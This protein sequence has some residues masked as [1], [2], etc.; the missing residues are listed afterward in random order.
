MA[1]S[2][3]TAPTYEKMVEHHGLSSHQLQEPCPDDVLHTLAKKM[4]RW[5]N[6]AVDL[7]LDKIV[8]DAIEI[9]QQID[10]EGK[11]RN[12]LERWKEKFGHAATYERLTRCLVKSERADLA[13]LV[14]EECKKLVPRPGKSSC[15]YTVV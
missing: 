14:C 8:V 13:D 6:V 11:R 10:E 9:K 1:M 12:L 3:T 4:N 7:E 15:V 2:T 5:Q